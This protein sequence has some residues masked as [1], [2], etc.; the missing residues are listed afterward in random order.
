MTNIVQIFRMNM[1]V[2]VDY[3]PHSPKHYKKPLKIHI[4]DEN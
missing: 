1:T 4:I 3:Q 2:G